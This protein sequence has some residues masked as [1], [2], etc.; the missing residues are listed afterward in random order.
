MAKSNKK[1]IV[2]KMINV[3]EDQ[4]DRIVAIANKEGRSRRT[5]IERMLDMYEG[6]KVKSDG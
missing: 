3:R 4:Y 5:V 6:K 1:A 2:P